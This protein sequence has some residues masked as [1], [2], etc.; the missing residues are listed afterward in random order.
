MI[1]KYH[2]E[3]IILQEIIILHPEQRKIR[4]KELQQL[5][6]DECYFDKIS[7]ES[8]S[9]FLFFIISIFIDSS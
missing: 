9:Y 8:L 1:K 5:V 7:Y 4:G 6:D 2:R 3:I